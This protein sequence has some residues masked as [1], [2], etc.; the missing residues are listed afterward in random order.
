MK[1]NQEKAFKL[2]NMLREYV[3]L[4]DVI[5]KG[6]EAEKQIRFIEKE[7]DK[8]INHDRIDKAKSLEVYIASKNF[9]G[10]TD[11]LNFISS[12]I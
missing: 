11:V 3:E 9:D 1:L 12:I 2:S 7:I 5:K 8:L 10:K 4:W 6:Q